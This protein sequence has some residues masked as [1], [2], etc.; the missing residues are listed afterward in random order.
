MPN[1][2]KE[3]K[4]KIWNDYINNKMWERFNEEALKEANWDWNQAA[5]CPYCGKKMLRAQYQGLQPDKEFSWDI[6][7]IKNSTNNSLN[8]L[9]P[10]HPRCNKLKG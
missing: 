4:R 5:P 6:D 8:N 2:T 3:E 10:M 7:H 9:Q 1:W